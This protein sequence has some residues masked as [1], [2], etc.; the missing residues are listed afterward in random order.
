MGGVRLVRD[1]KK[2]GV[3]VTCETC[4]HYFSTTDAEI[5]NYNTS[6][7]INPPLREKEDVEAVIAGLADGTIDIIATDHAPHDGGSKNTEF[8]LAAFGTAG[9]ETAF[10]LA[11]TYLADKKAVTLADLSR[12]MSAR[13]A[14]ILGLKGTGELLEGNTADI[15]VVGLNKKWKVDRDKMV[16]KSKNTLFHGWEL[17]GKVVCTIVE[18]EIKY[19]E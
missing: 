8:E 5:V 4:P 11:N 6:A 1:A 16:S 14:E 18:G 9:F 15:T 12:L 13:P 2:R 17:K 10:A 7:K 3:R 19:G